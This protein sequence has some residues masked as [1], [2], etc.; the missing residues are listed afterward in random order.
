M[1]AMDEALEEAF[2]NACK[3]S[4]TAKDLPI[5]TGKFWSNHMIP[6]KGADSVELDWKLSSFK[7]VNFHPTSG[8][9]A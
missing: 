8:P 6:C 3:T 2:L 9:Y 7:K 5:E 4:V 1:K